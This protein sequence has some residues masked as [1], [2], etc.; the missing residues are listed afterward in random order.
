MN[1]YKLNA[2]VLI[3]SDKRELLREACCNNRK[4][5]YS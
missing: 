1:S 2:H 5:I 4:Y 3:I